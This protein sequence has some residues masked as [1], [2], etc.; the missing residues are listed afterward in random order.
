M[1]YCSLSI[2]HSHVN[3]V[4][5]TNL[6]VVF[7]VPIDNFK[8]NLNYTCSYDNLKLESLTAVVVKSSVFWYIMPYSPLK[9]KQRFGGT[10]LTTWFMLVS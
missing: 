10:L 2:N 3:P 7:Q 8:R 6:T 1:I 5:G 9:V 4:C